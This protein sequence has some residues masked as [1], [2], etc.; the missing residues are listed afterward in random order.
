MDEENIHEKSTYVLLRRKPS[1]YKTIQFLGCNCDSVSVS[2]FPLLQITP[3]GRQTETHRAAS[4]QTDVCC[5]FTR[6]TYVTSRSPVT[7]QAPD[8]LLFPLAW[9][10]VSP[11]A[12]HLQLLVWQPRLK[13]R[14][15]PNV[16][17][18]LFTAAVIQCH[19]V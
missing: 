15:K 11:L 1:D 5:S 16:F 12:P 4:P 2:P 9:R 13:F 18:I 17:C 19:S 3:A 14:T 6:S 7:W 8:Q 10:W